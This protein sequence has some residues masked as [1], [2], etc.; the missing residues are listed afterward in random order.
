MED[1]KKKKWGSDVTTRQAKV[2][3]DFWPEQRKGV[4]AS[5]ER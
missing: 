5:E 3:P 4:G 1:K 2:F